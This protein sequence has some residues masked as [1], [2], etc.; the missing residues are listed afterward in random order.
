LKK[1]GIEEKRGGGNNLKGDS[2]KKK[3]NVC[4]GGDWQKKGKGKKRIG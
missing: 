4:V 1:D 2:K 3:C